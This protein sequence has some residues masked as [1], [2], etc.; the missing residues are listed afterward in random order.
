MRIYHDAR[1]LNVRLI[2]ELSIWYEKQDFVEIALFLG[3]AI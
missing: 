3:L 1:S 2:N